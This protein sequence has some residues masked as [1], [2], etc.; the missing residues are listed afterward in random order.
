MLIE[1][2]NEEMKHIKS[3]ARSQDTTISYF[4]KKVEELMQQVDKE[5]SERVNLQSEMRRI[6][7]LSSRNSSPR[8][9][10]DEDIEAITSEISSP[11]GKDCNTENTPRSMKESK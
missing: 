10:S 4:K 9:G 6:E 8:Q 3:T 2:V 1:K 7:H 11:A 5:K